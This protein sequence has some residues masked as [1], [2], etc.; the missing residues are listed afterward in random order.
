MFGTSVALPLAR[1]TRTELQYQLSASVDPYAAQGID[2]A[3]LQTAL[4]TVSDSF[5]HGHLVSVEIGK[6]SVHRRLQA[7]EPVTIHIQ[8]RIVCRNDH[9]ASLSCDA[10]K[11]SLE[12]LASDPTA[13][14][15]HATAII[16]AINAVAT[17]SG[18]ENAVIS[19]ASSLAQTLS[20]P[21]EIKITLPPPVDCVGSWSEWSECSDGTTTVV[22]GSGTM[23]RTYSVEVEGANGGVSCPTDSPQE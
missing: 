22:C 17:A 6:P 18:F 4:V 5:A 14:A 13:G 10:L 3:V 21:K 12:V 15:V 20:A 9:A 8:T 1:N 23:G 19:T 7:G 11:S 2:T 16:S